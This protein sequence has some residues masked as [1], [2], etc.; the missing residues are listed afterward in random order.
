MSPGLL[1]DLRLGALLHRSLEE[2]NRLPYPEYV[3]WKKFYMLEPWGFENTEFNVSRIL[4]QL[5][6]STQTK[7]SKL[8]A[9]SHWARN[10]RSLILNAIRKARAQSEIDPVTQAPLDL[11]TPEGRKTATDKVVEGFKAMFGA[12]L[13]DNRKQ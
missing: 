5:H 13:K 9:P 3:L 12:R 7:R 4:S 1:F 10:M 2:V 6:N 8:K 11:A